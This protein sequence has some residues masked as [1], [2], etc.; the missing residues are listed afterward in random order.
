MFSITIK[1]VLELEAAARKFLETFPRERI[2]AFYGKM[3]SGKTTFIKALCRS[4]GSADNITSP[5]FAMVNVYS[6]KGN[7]QIFHFDFYRM[8]KPEEVLDI[9]LEEYL[10]SGQYCFMEWPEKAGTFLPD[11]MVKVHITERPETSRLLT[12]FLR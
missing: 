5:T 7:G 6:T 2:F 8:K 9:G 10:D 1:S 11:R 3:G 12:A 4:L